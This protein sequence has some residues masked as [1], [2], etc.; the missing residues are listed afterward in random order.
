MSPNISF[1]PNPDD[2]NVLFAT[3][4]MRYFY[5]QNDLRKEMTEQAATVLSGEQ[6][7]FISWWTTCHGVDYRDIRRKV[8]RLTT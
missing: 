1:E 2:F 6:A 4:C 5:A 7:R 3:T 8:C